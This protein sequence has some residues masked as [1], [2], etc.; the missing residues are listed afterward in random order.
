MHKRSLVGLVTSCVVDSSSP[1]SMKG[2]L[3]T[4]DPRRTEVDS[5]KMSSTTVFS[6]VNTGQ[7]LLVMSCTSLDV[8]RCCSDICDLVVRLTTGS[9]HQ[10]KKPI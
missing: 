5:Q 8:P 10:F 9:A 1:F 4:T 2:V 3:G 6:L 7:T